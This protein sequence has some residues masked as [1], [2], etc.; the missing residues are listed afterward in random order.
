MNKFKVQ[1]TDLSLTHFNLTDQKTVTFNRCY[2]CHPSSNC[3]S[4]TLINVLSTRDNNLESVFLLHMFS[5]IELILFIQKVLQNEIIFFVLCSI[6][7]FHLANNPT[8]NK[9]KADNP[10]ADCPAVNFG[11]YSYWKNR[12]FQ[13]L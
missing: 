4:R 6:N 13:Y 3:V 1:N 11:N 10:K 12:L 7:S 8:K 5:C 9:P 2:S